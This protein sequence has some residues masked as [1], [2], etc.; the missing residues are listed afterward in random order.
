MLAG[1]RH[2]GS[3]AFVVVLSVLLLYVVPPDVVVVS[4]SPA[5]HLGLC[6][7]HMVLALVNLLF[8]YMRNHCWSCV[9]TKSVSE[10]MKD[11]NMA[12][13]SYVMSPF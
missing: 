9:M 4:F 8:V 1:W 3:S 5:Q 11:K 12:T 7:A 6:Y 13:C 10:K 2:P